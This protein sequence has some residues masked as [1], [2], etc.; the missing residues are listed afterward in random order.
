MHIRMAIMV[1]YNIV[2][3]SQ[4]EAWAKTLAADG[5]MFAACPLTELDFV[6]LALL[7]KEVTEMIQG[8][9]RIKAARLASTDVDEDPALAK[10]LKGN[11]LHDLIRDAALVQ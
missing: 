10:L 6:N 4:T 3:L 8:S 2:R 5:F 7:R 11:Y 1:M 9:A